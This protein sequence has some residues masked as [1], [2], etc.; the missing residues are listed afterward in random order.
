MRAAT[1]PMWRPPILTARASARKRV[2]LQARHATPSAR[3]SSP[4]SSTRGAPKPSH[5]GQAPY[6]W[7]QENRRGSGAGSP[8]P[9]PGQ[10]R[11]VE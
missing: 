1:S 9:Q 3:R 7:L 2:P 6:F 11:R 8:V 5:S 10:E 4:S